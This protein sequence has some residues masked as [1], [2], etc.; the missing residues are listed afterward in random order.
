MDNS[1]IDVED[2]TLI[3]EWSL[4]A[5]KSTSKEAIFLNIETLMRRAFQLRRHIDALKDGKQKRQLIRKYARIIWQI[6]NH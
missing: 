5:L 3:R 2:I 4:S 6:Q 1:L